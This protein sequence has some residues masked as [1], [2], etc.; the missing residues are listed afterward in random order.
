M[1][2]IQQ[3]KNIL[4]ENNI[5]VLKKFGQNFLI[6][7]NVLNKIIKTANISPQDTILEIGPGLGVLTFE[8]AKR[9]N[10]VIAIEKDRKF[11][12]IFKKSLETRGIKN[13]SLVNGD[14]LKVQRSTLNVQR[15]KLVA[16]LPY[17]IATAVIMKF[18]Q[19]ENPPQQIVAMIQKE[20]AQ[21]ITATPPQ[22]NKLAIFCQF[23]STPKIID[24]VP[25]TAFYP[26]PKVDSAILE[27]KEPSALYSGHSVPSRALFEQ[28]VDIGFSHPRKTLLNNFAE[29]WAPQ[30]SKEKISQWLL[31][32]N[33]QPNQ[34]P[35]TLTINDWLKLT[36]TFKSC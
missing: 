11:F 6:S 13:V 14:A 36:K 27:F 28:I 21:R 19:A 17:N 24:I 35:E 7:E 9:A 8:L 1:L 23:Y 2:N 29:P 30:F 4:K 25:P 33:I 15:Y 20:V 5:A 31:E 12:E 3:I 34:R 32:N 18:L 22:M 16:N 26:K 10:K